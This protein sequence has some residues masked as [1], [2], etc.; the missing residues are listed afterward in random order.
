MGIA[1]HIFRAKS[2]ISTSLFLK[3]ALLVCAWFAYL[4]WASASSKNPSYF[5]V[6]RVSLGAIC[7]HRSRF[8][9]IFVHKTAANKS[10]LFKNHASWHLIT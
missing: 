2:L 3:L 5:H 6:M 4:Y 1:F 7:F 10:S 8:A 9:Q